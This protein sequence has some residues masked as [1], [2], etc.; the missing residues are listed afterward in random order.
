[1]DARDAHG[2]RG[3]WIGSWIGAA[4]GLVYVEVNAAP[5]SAGPRVAVRVAGIAA[6]AAVAWLLVR[7]RPRDTGDDGPGRPVFGRAYWLI[8]LAEVVALFVG[9]RVVA[10]PL[11][12]PDAGVAWVSLVV[13]AHF[14]PLAALFRV[15]PFW[16]LGLGIAACGVAGLALAVGDASAA[17]IAVVGGLVP[18]VLLLASG[19]L[20]GWTLPPAAPL[21]A[22]TTSVGSD[23]ARP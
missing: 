5:L 23:D 6:F 22:M 1:M 19:W 18:G 17:A 3:Q 9:V 21:D 16:W 20:G 15:R 12:M 8:V 7:R 13:G 4:F 10:G 14:L 11:G 2:G